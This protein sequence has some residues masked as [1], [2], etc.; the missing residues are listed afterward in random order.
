MA[1]AKCCDRC[2]K[3]YL[4]NEYIVNHEVSGYPV[5]GFRYVNASNAYYPLI[6]L[7]DECL[8]KLVDW[9]RIDEEEQHA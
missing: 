2:K 9:M 1:E 3:F 8:V 4:K 7:C 5:V 6:D